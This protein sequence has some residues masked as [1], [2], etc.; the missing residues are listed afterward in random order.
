MLAKS[1]YV[2]TIR[3]H[4][5]WL[6]FLGPILSKAGRAAFGVVLIL[7]ATAMESVAQDPCQYSAFTVPAATCTYPLKPKGSTEADTKLALACLWKTNAGESAL[8]DLIDQLK[9]QSDISSPRSSGLIYT[10]LQRGDGPQFDQ[11]KDTYIAAMGDAGPENRFDALKPPPVKMLDAIAKA[12]NF[13][14]PVTDSDKS[15]YSLAL[16]ACVDDRIGK[17]YNIR[18]ERPRLVTINHSFLRYG[19]S[20]YAALYELLHCYSEYCEN[21]AGACANKLNDLEVLRAAYENSPTDLAARIAKK[22]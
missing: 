18:T 20:S 19:D 13:V 22:M 21:N 16:I 15:A 3:L 6:D 1:E 5:R 11:N 12:N 4:R 2:R 7:A 14:K 9:D 10:E 17:M 8:L